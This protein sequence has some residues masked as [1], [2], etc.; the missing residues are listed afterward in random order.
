MS[1]GSRLGEIMIVFK[2]PCKEFRQLEPIGRFKQ[3]NDSQRCSLE[4]YPVW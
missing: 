3:G 1:V 2:C 4:G